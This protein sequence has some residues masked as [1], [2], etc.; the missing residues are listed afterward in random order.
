MAERHTPGLQRVLG[1]NALFATAYGN[2]GSSIYYALGLVASFALGLTP[3]VFVI[4]GGIFYLTAATYAEATAMYP[5][6]GGSSSFARHAFNEFWSFFAAW[7][8]MLNYVITVAISAFFVPHYIGGL[9]WAYLKTSPGDIIVGIAV[10]VVL[11]AINIV[12]VKEAAGVNV[13][14][15]FTDFST[16][17]ALVILGCV[18][19]LSPD[20]L[21]NNVHLGTVPTWKNFIIAIPVAMIAYTGIE[22]ISNMAEEARDEAHTIPKAIKGVVAAVFA[23]YALLP[24]VALSALPVT[25]NAAGKCQT[26]L[27]LP[28]EQGGY[29]GDPVL[30]IVKHLGLGPLQHAGEIYVGLL[31]A[32]ILFIATNAGIIGV[33]RLVY[34]MGIHRQLPE[35]LRQLHPKYRTPWIGIIVFGG[36]ACITLIPGQA[37]FLGNMYAFGAMLSFTIAHISVIRLRIKD[38]NRERP[39]RGP[40]TLRV[41]GHDLP[42]FAVLGA[43]GTGFAWVTV[44]ILHFNVAVAGIGWL[45]VGVCVYIVYRH[46]QG[47]DLTTTTKIALPKAARDTEAEYESVLVAFDEHGFVPDVLATA[48]RMAAR[49]RRGI[50]VLVT[51][52]V[53]S[54]SPINARM[55]AQEELAQSIIEEAKVQ[56]GRRVSGHWVK[57]RPGQT[58]RQIV[59]EARAMRAA[60]IVMP[61]SHDGSGF[62]RALATVLR[63]RPCRVIVES[64]PAPGLGRHPVAA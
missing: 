41:R 27:G 24:A 38:P 23:I 46:S 10:I 37:D 32:T 26:L 16:Q 19:V 20:T 64:P 36:I 39:Y 9:F 47:L 62:G 40:G 56:A 13:V 45:A 31:A 55:P 28:E 44:T 34:S 3:I 53:P 49:R 59:D 15:A 63:E 4:A 60:A 14:L 2:V 21:I 35:Q 17:L 11:C 61:M 18:L 6:A 51:I 22:T 25:C 7:G 12:G 5:E 48:T 1:V 57:V 54:S 43:I 58:G 8:Q 33:S 50:H 29:A 30:G 42:L 52:S